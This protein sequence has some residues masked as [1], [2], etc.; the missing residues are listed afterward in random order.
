MK[1]FQTISELGPEGSLHFLRMGEAFSSCWIAS[2]PFT[3]ETVGRKSMIYQVD[4]G[5][6]HGSSPE[7]F[8]SENTGNSHGTELSGLDVAVLLWIVSS[9]PQ[10]TFCLFRLTT[11]M[12]LK[13]ESLIYS[14]S[15]INFIFTPAGTPV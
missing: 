11:R 12:A 9:I 1:N 4:P 14:G 13:L 2:E 3:V 8:H 6:I 15:D 5:L 7:I 10:L